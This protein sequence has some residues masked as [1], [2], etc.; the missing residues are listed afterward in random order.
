M[1]LN[2][3][4]NVDKPSGMTSSDVV[5]C[6]R[7][8]FST[9]AVGHMG[10]LDPIG[11]GVLPIGIGKSTRLFDYLLK[12]DKV[13][14]TNFLFGLETDTLDIQGKTLK[15]TDAIPSL[16]E[17]T[18]AVSYF[19][20]KQNQIPPL[21]SAKNVNG[22]RAYDLARAGKN[23]VLEGKEIEIFDIYD[24]EQSGNSF[25]LT[26]N[27]SSGTYIRSLCRDIA[28]KLNSYAIMTSIRRLRSGN[29]LIEDSHTLDEISNLKEQV[30]VLP[31]ACL[32]IPTVNIDDK[33]YVKLSNGAS[34]V[35]NQIVDGKYFVRCKGEL[36]GI[37][38]CVSGI[39]KIKTY[40]KDL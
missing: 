11:T 8:I 16:K 32:N 6:I 27:C 25:N 30:I 28:Y 40:L 36:F 23:F 22:V 10:T 26:V 33:F 5:C 4:I 7:K 29:F 35:Q 13:Y 20:G 17:F 9:R 24:I 19:V 34:I 14:R 2:G 12:K 37:A 39:L 21:Y 38:D 3:V 18:D 31:E 1:Y 15:K